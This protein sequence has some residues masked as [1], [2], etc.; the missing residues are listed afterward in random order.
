MERP[1][2]RLYVPR[3]A[4]LGHVA[5]ALAVARV[6]ARRPSWRHA[7][8]Y[9]AVSLA[10]DADVLAFRFGVPYHD[11]LGHRGLTH[12]FAFAALC[13]VVALFAG[14]S[15]RS[16]LLVAVTAASHPLLDALTNGGLGVALFFPFSA[17]RFFFPWRPLPVAPIGAGMLSARGAYVMLVEALA[18][19]PLLAIGL[20][21]GRKAVSVPVAVERHASTE[22]LRKPE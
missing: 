17:Q 14:A 15:K 22:I 11:I 4:S 1:A 21:P 7:V 18:S 12:S 8:A 3:M 5:V 6:D 2:S 9:S 13:G 19:A 16:S 20:W 10:P